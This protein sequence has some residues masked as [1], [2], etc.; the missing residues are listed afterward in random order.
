MFTTKG[1]QEYVYIYIYILDLHMTPY[2]VIL[3][4]KRR[5]VKNLAREK[6]NTT[7]KVNLLLRRLIRLDMRGF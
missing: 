4:V 3:M 7:Q 1:S 5:A 2:G 6:K